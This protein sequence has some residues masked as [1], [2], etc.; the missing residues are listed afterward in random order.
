MKTN[1]IYR[2]IAN[3][4]AIGGCLYLVALAIYLLKL[5]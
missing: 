2:N 5:M 4:F 1:N 3:G